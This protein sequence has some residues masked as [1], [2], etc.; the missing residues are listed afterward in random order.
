MAWNVSKPRQ[1]SRACSGHAIEI[2]AT[3]SNPTWLALLASWP[4]SMASLCLGHILRRS[5]PV[6]RFTGW[7]LFICKRGKRRHNQAGFY[8]AVPPVTASGYDW[9][10]RFLVEYDLRRQ[11]EA[12]KEMMGMI[13]R[14]DNHEYLS[15]NA[16]SA[17]IM[18]TVAAVIKNPEPLLAYSWRRMLPG[19]IGRTP[20]GRVMRHPSP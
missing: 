17:L 14:T 5:V 16:E 11:S 3:T 20:R 10:N 1:H 8:W 12:G 2:G 9:T 4:Q 18:N 15:A 19:A 7:L 13:F 6:E